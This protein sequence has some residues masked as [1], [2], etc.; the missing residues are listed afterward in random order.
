M[1]DTSAGG[2]KTSMTAHQQLLDS[3]GTVL[4]CDN[5]YDS[6]VFNAVKIDS[7]L[8]EKFGHKERR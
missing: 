5:R 8:E 2:P 4:F 3:G 7:G 1:D 6:N